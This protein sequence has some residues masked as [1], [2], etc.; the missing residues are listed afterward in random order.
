MDTFSQRDLV[1]KIELRDFYDLE[2]PELT[3][4]AFR[5]ILYALEKVGCITPLG[6]GVYGLWNPSL[7]SNKKKYVPDLSLA[8]EE[9][10]EEVRRTFP[11]V[12]YLAWETRALHE[13]MIHQPGQNQI[14]LEIE[15]V[16]AESVFNR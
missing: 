1:R 12:Q 8:V 9:L 15:K 14:I 11:C 16:A 10:C 5:R 7:P 4:Q 3:E 2:I 13:F 6:A